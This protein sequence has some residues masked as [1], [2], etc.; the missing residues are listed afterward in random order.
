MPLLA[1]FAVVG[2]AL[3]GLLYVAEAQLGP[4]KSLDISTNFHGV[5]Q[6]WK[7]A[8]APA[9]VLTVRDAPVAN[10]GT[11]AFAQSK[12]EEAQSPKAEAAPTPRKATRV[13]KSKRAQKSAQKIK[14]ES[15]NLF[16]HSITPRPAARIW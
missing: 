1:Y 14:N 7:A 13:A 3:L 11:E 12:V 6:P 16:A 2:F 10:I 8:R 5:P 15:G 9:P 4:P